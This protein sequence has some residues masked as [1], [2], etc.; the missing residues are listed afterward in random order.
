MALAIWITHALNF[1]VW[2]SS[3]LL[4]SFN[5]SPKSQISTAYRYSTIRMWLNSA[6]PGVFIDLVLFMLLK[7]VV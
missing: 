4:V 3:V 1:N 7:P 6:I 5:Y 2:T